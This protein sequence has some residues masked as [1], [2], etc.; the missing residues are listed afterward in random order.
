MPGAKPTERG[1]RVRGWA[2]G[3][4]RPPVSPLSLLPQGLLPRAAGARAHAGRPHLCS[5]LPG[6]SWRPQVGAAVVQGW[7]LGTVGASDWCCLPPH[8]VPLHP[9]TMP[10]PVR[11]WMVMPGSQRLQGAASSG[12]RGAGGPILGKPRYKNEEPAPTVQRRRGAGWGGSGGAVGGGGGGAG[13]ADS[14]LACAATCWLPENPRRRVPAPWLLLGGSLHS[15]SISVSWKDP[16]SW[17]APH[18]LGGSPNPQRVLAFWG[19]SKRPLEHP[20]PTRAPMQGW[21]EPLPFQPSA[22]TGHRAGLLGGF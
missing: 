17:E 12:N 18:V 4:P 20:C 6:V 1:G 19:G 3:P 14:L 10:E 21:A 9:G 8:P 11:G 5:V 2:A 13:R 7:G 22:S 15:G 16:P